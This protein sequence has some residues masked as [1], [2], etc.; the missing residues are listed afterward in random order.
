MSFASLTFR[1]VT[2][3]LLT[4]A[5]NSAAQLMLRAAALRGAEV[6]NPITLL[7]SPLFLAALAAYGAS[8]LTWVTV[9]K[10][11]PLPTA[12]PFVALMY[13]VVPLAAWKVF[14]DPVS[15]RMLGGMALV[16]AGIVIVVRG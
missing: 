4:V 8:V 5:L 6:A 16:I 12:I 9:L 15:A 3:A 10:R 1:D 13:V 14:D 2:L 7:K 11:V